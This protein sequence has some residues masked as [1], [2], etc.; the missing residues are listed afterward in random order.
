[1]RTKLLMLLADV[2]VQAAADDCAASA[3]DEDD[4]LCGLYRSPRG[5]G[6]D[7]TGYDASDDADSVG[8]PDVAPGSTVR[9]AVTS[10]LHQLAGQHRDMLMALGQHLTPAQQRAVEFAMACGPRT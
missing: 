2:L 8:I 5:G 9:Q 3:S 7:V 4:D 1:M 6:L 10:P